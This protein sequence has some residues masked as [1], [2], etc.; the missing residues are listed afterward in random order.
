VWI[1]RRSACSVVLARPSDLR[2][3][4]ASTAA[5]RGLQERQWLIRLDA[6][7]N[8]GEASEDAGGL[9]AAPMRKGVRLLAA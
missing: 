2:S 1:D 6:L 3:G 8:L 9:A 7:L 5:A 4:I